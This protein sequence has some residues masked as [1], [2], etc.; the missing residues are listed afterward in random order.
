[1]PSRTIA[2]NAIVPLVKVFIIPVP[3]TKKPAIVLTKFAAALV[4]VSS[5]IA[6]SRVK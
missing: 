1:L 5:V 4:G 2:S 6:I 3:G